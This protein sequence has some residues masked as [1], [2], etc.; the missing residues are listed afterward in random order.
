MTTT[1]TQDAQTDAAERDEILDGLVNDWLTS[2]EAIDKHEELLDQIGAQIIKRLGIGGRHELML[3]VGV[4]VQGPASRFDAG[5]AAEILTADQLASIS[6]AKPS[7][8]L[9]KKY[10]PGVLVEQCQ[11]ATGKPSVRRLA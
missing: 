4:R 5:K 11:V 9:A 10:L 8:T 6:E 3:G 2:K 1:E 7:S